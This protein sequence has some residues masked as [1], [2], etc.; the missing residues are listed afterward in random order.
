[1]PSLGAD[2]DRGKLVEWLVKPG[3]QVHR[4]EAM[5]T[6]DTEKTLMDVESFEDGTVTELLAQP[7]DTVLV[8][9]AMARITQTP[10]PG[11]APDGVP[12]ATTTEIQPTPAPPPETPHPPPVPEAPPEPPTTPPTAPPAPPTPPV[13]RL[14]HRLGVDLNRLHGTGRGGAVT[15]KDVE[16]AA[17]APTAETGRVRSSPR[18][19]K[20]ATELGLDLAAIPGTGPA[21]AVTE[22]D[23]RR[24]AEAAPA[25]SGEPHPHPQAAPQPPTPPEAAARTEGL[26]R[27]LGSLMSRSKQTIPHYYLGTTVDLQPAID[28]MRSTNAQRSVAARLVPAALLLKA[29]ALAAHDIPEVNGFYTDGRFRPSPAVHLGVAVSLRGGGLVAPALH[30]A[31]TLPVDLLMERLRDLVA[32]ARNR[33]LQRAEMADPTLT[34]TNLG[35]LGVESVYGVIYPPQVAMVG[36]GRVVEQPWAQDGMLGVRHVVT[37]TLSADHRVSDGLDGGRFLTRMA[38]LLQTPEEL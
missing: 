10:A 7:G 31:D 3:D 27:S 11:A 15:R 6:V 20:T 28:W 5:A 13:R 8:G 18:A 25:R 30:D 4:G 29:C 12:Q 23:V 17:A 9:T 35:D 14:A 26:R 36:F 24:A 34:V 19:R 16:R 1:M 37:A 38:E 21:G 2:M 33:H 32:R 22:A